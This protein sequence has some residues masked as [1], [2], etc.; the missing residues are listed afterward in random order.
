MRGGC[1]HGG[2]PF[3]AVPALEVVRVRL[4][5][6]R[7]APTALDYQWPWNA[8]R[9]FSWSFVIGVGLVGVAPKVRIFAGFSERRVGRRYRD[10][11]RRAVERKS[12]KCASAR[13]V[14]LPRF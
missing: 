6:L 13:E 14:S 1:S 4:K 3:K 11:T 9:V 12:K 8:H 7:T 10:E 2:H 5:H